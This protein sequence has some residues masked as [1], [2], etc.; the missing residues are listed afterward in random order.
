MTDF[1]YQ[2]TV[3]AYHG[4]DESVLAAVLLRGAQLRQSDNDYD[5]LGRGIYF[6][7]HGPQRALEWARWRARTGRGVHEPTILGAIVHLGNCFDLLDTA[8]TELLGRMFPIYRQACQAARL[9]LPRNLP[10]SGEAFGDV[11]RRHL[12]CAVLNWVLDSC[13]RAERRRFHTVRGAFT[14]GVPAFPG[15]KVMA[16]SHIQIAVRNPAAILGYFRPAIDNRA[17]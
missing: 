5:W 16:K 14:E 12:D 10:V 8:F 1:A 13:E 11:V 6:W 9:P 3:I 7:E 15:S 4:C 17:D 2:R